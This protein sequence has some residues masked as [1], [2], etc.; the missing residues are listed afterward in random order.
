MQLETVGEAA[1]CSPRKPEI[2]VTEII[3]KQEV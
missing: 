1:T 3:Y 2:L